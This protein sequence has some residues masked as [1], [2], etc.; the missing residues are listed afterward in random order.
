[1]Q[2]VVS[3]DKADR[4]LN[5][6]VSSKVAYFQPLSLQIKIPKKQTQGSD[7]TDKDIQ[8]DLI[9]SVHGKFV[10]KQP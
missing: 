10:A 9:L 8:K 6:C 1:L 4:I 7:S 3:F 2:E 5:Q